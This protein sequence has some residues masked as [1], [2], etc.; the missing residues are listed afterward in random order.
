M[1]LEDLVNEV[2]SQSHPT[3]P[4]ISMEYDTFYHAVAFTNVFP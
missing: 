2:C 4:N 1:Q 3:T